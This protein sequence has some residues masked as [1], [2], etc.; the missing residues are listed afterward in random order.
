VKRREFIT[1]LGGAA[2]AWP[3]AASAQQ[4]TSKVFRVG[5][6]VTGSLR[7]PEQRSMTDAFRQ[8]LRERGYL[9][10]QN[11]VIEYR[12]AE[13]KSSGSQSWRRSLLISIPT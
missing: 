8:G 13:G 2:A 1:L 5:F 7:S 6:M 11:I 10:G 9:E 3:L 12:A 4:P